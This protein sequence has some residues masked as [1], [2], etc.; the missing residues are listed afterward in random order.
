M[1]YG[2][3]I[4]M[5]KRI[6]Y[7]KEFNLLGENLSVTLKCRKLNS[8]SL[9]MSSK[10]ACVDIMRSHTTYNLTDDVLAYDLSVKNIV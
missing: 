5:H 9:K 3:L 4:V 7:Y 10:V 2:F 8:E 6:H 1:S